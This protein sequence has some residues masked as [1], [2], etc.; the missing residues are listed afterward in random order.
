LETGAFKIHPIDGYERLRDVLVHRITTRPGSEFSDLYFLFLAS[1]QL[2]SGIGGRE[3]KS[4]LLQLT[5]HSLREVADGWL[6]I[7]RYGG[8]IPK[9]LDVL[10]QL[11][12]SALLVRLSRG[13][14][15]GHNRVGPTPHSLLH[16]VLAEQGTSSEIWEGYRGWL[17]ELGS[18]AGFV[19]PLAHRHFNE[20]IT[21]HFYSQLE[22]EHKS[23]IELQIDLW[24]HN[25]APVRQKDHFWDL[26]KPLVFE[27]IEA[28]ASGEVDGSRLQTPAIH[29]APSPGSYLILDAPDL[30]FL[31][32]I[33]E[34]VTVYASH[35]KKPGARVRRR[36]REWLAQISEFASRELDTLPGEQISIS[37]EEE[38]RIVLRWLIA[39]WLADE[40]SGKGAAPNTISGKFSILRVLLTEF[41]EMMP[42]HLGEVQ[43]QVIRDKRRLARSTFNKYLTVLDHFQK[44]ARASL[45]AKAEQPF[46]FPRIYQYAVQ[47]QEVQLVTRP[48]LEEILGFLKSR[49]GVKGL[50]YY[51]SLLQVSFGFRAQSVL[52]LRLDGVK[53]LTGRYASALAQPIKSR[54]AFDA[55]QPI[56]YIDPGISREL[57]KFIDIRRKETKDHSKLLLATKEN[58]ALTYQQYRQ[59]VA[60][61]MRVAGVMVTK[62]PF[63]QSTH[64]FR[65]YAANR[66]QALGLH[67]RLI[68]DLMN[69]RH[70]S[71]TVQSYLHGISFVLE[72][73]LFPRTIVP[74]IS[75]RQT[76]VA[77]M[78]GL[79][80]RQIRYLEDDVILMN[81]HRRRYLL[82]EVFT[83][84]DHYFKQMKEEDCAHWR[85]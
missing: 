68:R 75:F 79:S 20:I 18:E 40:F 51:A 76:A 26:A 37:G 13:I 56:A 65:H 48:E 58:Q 66:W 29:T 24:P 63:D 33:K 59:V 43:M 42:Y 7:P 69:H 32:E 64:L 11:L 5:D 16:P 57:A 67:L 30:S 55:Q 31:D 83:I 6:Y 84:I 3:V 81:F 71:T 25:P 1:I 53:N 72:K 2:L 62:L 60:D 17:K 85:V 77:A 23:L 28:F 38:R 50:A 12:G 36:F 22:E 34:V 9:K 4:A 14:G 46:A 82:G 49:Q 45:E 80:A 21:H 73:Q 61:A 78:I 52:E 47:I 10:S 39:G 54:A 44:Y 8:E 70:D 15:K 35:K 74:D 27:Q 19:F 41:P